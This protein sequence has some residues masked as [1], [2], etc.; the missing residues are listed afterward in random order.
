MSKQ[1]ELIQHFKDY[2]KSYTDRGASIESAAFNYTR[3][4]P[5]RLPHL[6]LALME[7]K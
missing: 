7:K 1:E 3:E 5:A 2:L 4:F 6:L